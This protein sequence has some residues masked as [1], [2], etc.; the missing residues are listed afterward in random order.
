MCAAPRAPPPD[1]TR[2]TFGRRH[3]GRGGRRLR[4]SNGRAECEGRGEH[5]RHSSCGHGATLVHGVNGSDG[6]RDGFRIR[7]LALIAVGDA[8][9]LPDSGDGSD[10][11]GEHELIH[12]RFLEGADYAIVLPVVRQCPLAPGSDG[13]GRRCPASV[14]IAARSLVRDLVGPFAGERGDQPA[15]EVEAHRAPRAA[16]QLTR[17]C[18]AYD[19]DHRLDASFHDDPGRVRVV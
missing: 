10:G 7:R 6:D 16:G 14:S 4:I 17:R 11:G 3:V 2:Q 15:G 12:R 1:S 13:L 19:R 18:D 8:P 5:R 9:G